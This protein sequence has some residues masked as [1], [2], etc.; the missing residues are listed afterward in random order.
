MLTVDFARL[1]GDVDAVVVLRCCFLWTV[2]IEASSFTRRKHQLCWMNHW[3]GSREN[4]QATL[5][6]T[7]NSM[8]FPGWFPHQPLLGMNAPC[9]R[10]RQDGEGI[11]TLTHLRRHDLTHWNLSWVMT[12]LT[13]WCTP[14]DKLVSHWTLAISARIGSSPSYHA[15]RPI[16]ATVWGM[17][18]TPLCGAESLSVSTIHETSLS[19][20]RNTWQHNMVDLTEVA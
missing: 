15:W 16:R 1:A 2:P 12:S 13:R 5:V 17:H 8:G 6:L 20:V 19:C 10:L 7:T 9:A 3:V 11:P 14:S 4:L 18:M